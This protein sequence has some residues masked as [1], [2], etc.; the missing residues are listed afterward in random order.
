MPF[1]GGDRSLKSLTKFLKKHATKPFE[2][3][4]KKGEWR[5]WG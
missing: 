5:G 1:E 4:K 3:P 2:L